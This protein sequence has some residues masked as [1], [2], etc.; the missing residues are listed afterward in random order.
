MTTVKEAID[1]GG[2]YIFMDDTVYTLILSDG[3]QVGPLTMSG[4][5]FISDEYLGASFFENRLS[6]VIIVSDDREEHHGPMKFI[7]AYS[8]NKKY[9]FSLVDLSQEELW[10]MKMEATMSYFAMMTDIDL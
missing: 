6:S 10:Q 7:Q 1:K 2:N 5:C 4:T 3:T 8:P 9:C